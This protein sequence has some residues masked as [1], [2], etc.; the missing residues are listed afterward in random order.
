MA[1][2]KKEAFIVFSDLKGFSKLTADEQETY[3]VIHVHITSKA[4]K[5][6]L[7]DKAKVYNTW[8]DAIIAVFQDGLQAAEFMLSYRKEARKSMQMIAED[9][10]VLPRIAGHY[11]EVSVFN[12]P[13][14]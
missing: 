5:P 3:L 7:E 14:I 2:D 11:G 9:K 10:K 12:D 4:I 13:L 1:V 8:G 6:F